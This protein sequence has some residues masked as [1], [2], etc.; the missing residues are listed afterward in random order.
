MSAVTD[1]FDKEIAE[2]EADI[3]ERPDARVQRVEHLKTLRKLYL[4]GPSRTGVMGRPSDTGDPI[5][6][7]SVSLNELLIAA[8]SNSGRFEA[9]PRLASGR[10]PSPQ[11]VRALAI[12]KSYLADK[13]EPVKTSVL[14]EHLKSE[15]IVIKGADPRNNLSAML[16]NDPAFR[17][18]G[19]SGWTLK[20]KETA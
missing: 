7:I 5:S 17:S 18:N 13:V 2:L 4:A 9:R 19:R 14:F 20:Q 1:A 10:R 8:Q 6:E 12:I 3:V 15:D 16:S 11:R